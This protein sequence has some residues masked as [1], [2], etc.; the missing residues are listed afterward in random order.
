MLSLTLAGNANNAAAR[1]AGES[2]MSAASPAPVSRRRH[3]V[4]GFTVA[5]MFLAYTDRVNLAVAV[6]AMREQFHWSQSVKGLVLAGFFIGYLLF[7]VASGALAQRFGGKRVLGLAVLW[8]SLF[9]LLTPAAAGV[10]VAVLI[11]ARV[12]LGLGEAAVLPASYELFSRWVPL[13]ERTRSLALFLSG[14]P[15]GQIVGLVGTAYLTARLGWPATF[16]VFGALGLV[17]VAAFWRGVHSNPAADV[18]VSAAERALLPVSAP[19]AAA[20]TPWRKLLHSPLVL[21]FIAAHFC[22]NWALYVLVSW[23]PSYFHEHLGLSVQQ[24]GWYSAL[25][26][27]ANFL[28]LLSGGAVADGAIARGA[29]PLGVRRALAATGLAGAALCLLSLPGASS[30]QVALTIAC[31]AAALTGLACA[32]FTAVPLDITPRHAPMLIGFS[33]TLATIPGIIAVALTGWQL[34]VTH[35]YTSTF[36]LSAGITAAGAL[37]LAATARAP[38]PEL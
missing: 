32:G 19:G 31:A 16:Y 24:S 23:L 37:L 3:V 15:L 11:G 5:A 7:Q 9:A 8:W 17:W 1:A 33:N 28:A 18:G 34:D 21:S 12:G 27:L 10:S 6:V 35:N 2:P 13:T 4:V 26:W 29:R 14:I 25:P 38:V 22:H 20:P 36:V 30:A